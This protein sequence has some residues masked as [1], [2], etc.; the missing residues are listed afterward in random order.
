VMLTSCNLFI[1]EDLE[2]Q[3]LEYSG[4]GYDNVVSE[5]T[6]NYTLEYQYKKT[7]LELNAD[8]PLT[9]HIVRVETIDSASCHIIYFDGS[10]SIDELPRVGQ[11]IVS[12]NTELFPKGLC[13]KVGI[14]EKIGGETVLTCKGVHPQDAFEQL[15]FNASFPADEFLDEYDMYDE[16]GNFLAH[17]DNREFNSRQQT[18]GSGDE[19]SGLNINIPFDVPFK[20]TALREKLYSKNIQL[21]MTGG[22]EGKLYVN[23][24]Y[25]F[26][27]G[28][29]TSARLAGA[30]EAGVK[31][32]ILAGMASPMKIWGN[33][34]LLKG[35]VRITVGP[36]VVVPVFGVHFSWQAHASVS[37]EIG[38]RKEFDSEV[39]FNYYEFYTK[40][41]LEK[42]KPT[43]IK[44]TLSAAG[45]IDLLVLKLSFGFGVFS[46]ELSVRQEIYGKLSL[47]ITGASASTTYV[48]TGSEKATTTIDYHPKLNLSFSIG[49]AIALVA[50]GAVVSAILDKVKQYVKETATL[51]E[52]IKKFANGDYSDWIDYAAGNYKSINP[53]ILTEMEK[54]LQGLEGDKR[55]EA[56]N[57]MID[58]RSKENSKVNLSDDWFYTSQNKQFLKP[59]DIEKNKDN[60]A[61][62]YALRLGPY[63][64]DIMK[65]PIIDRYLFPTI[66]EGSFRMGR[67]WDAN[68]EKL[69]FT[70]EYA[71]EDPGL[72]SLFEDYYP[73]FAIKLGN[74]AILYETAN[75]GEKITSKTPEG[76]KFTATFP[77]LAA[78]QTYACVPGYASSKDGVA[79]IWDKGMTFSATT[80]TINIVSMRVTKKERHEQYDENG[81]PTGVTYS[82]A[83]DTYT[84]VKGSR[85]VSEWGLIDLN[86]TNEKTR[87]HTSKT[88][89]LKSGQYIHHWSI[90][91]T[92][93]S[94][95]AISLQPYLFAKVDG[96]K[97]DWSEAKFFPRY[98]AAIRDDYDFS[99]ASRSLT[100]SYF[101]NNNDYKV[102][103]DSIT[104]AY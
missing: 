77:G 12:N 34:D 26:K 103:L 84:E 92:K 29:K 28:L 95:V 61:K 40:D 3:L 59:E 58:K 22:L 30:I 96:S 62:E 78:D 32:S 71:L 17:V 90:K 45:T 7:T 98:D 76:K 48:P 8:H 11:C 66:K 83:F 51:N 74:Q 5:Q 88:A 67:N 38:F 69:I 6:E 13:D 99:D 70:A 24:E 79:R 102:E 43:S 27:D 56:I 94:R 35:K 60:E 47:K 44:A 87:V 2:N 64:P 10:V 15:E 4:K 1:D 100:D 18:R 52:S 54:Q 53:K 9:R 20:S 41:Y 21:S 50:K 91:N 25:S 104:V 75:D 39:G 31:I 68:R 14:V 81:D 89:S 36:V 85:N 55:K 49:F 63:F 73:G 101:V 57:A 82:Y 33:D 65:W 93:K 37:T 23:F 72:F 42:A 16:D 86:D 19:E 80:P 97:R 46:S